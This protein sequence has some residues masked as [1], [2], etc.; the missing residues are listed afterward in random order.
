[1]AKPSNYIVGARRISRLSDIG[2]KKKRKKPICLQQPYETSKLSCCARFFPW[3]LRNQS[4]GVQLIWPA[5]HEATHYSGSI[6]NHDVFHNFWLANSQ[7]SEIGRVA[8]DATGTKS[9][10]GDK[11]LMLC[12]KKLN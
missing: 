12:A 4:P 5:L 8:W 1:M 6:I 9:R 10:D 7:K 11:S 2:Y 3:F